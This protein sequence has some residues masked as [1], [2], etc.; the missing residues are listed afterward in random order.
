MFC[1]LNAFPESISTLGHWMLQVCL[2][3]TAAQAMLYKHQLS[4]SFK[5]SKQ[6]IHR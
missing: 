2:P 1:V 3:R 4:F 5:M 6:K